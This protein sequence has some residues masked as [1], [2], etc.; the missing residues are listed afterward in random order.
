[1][2]HA[3]LLCFVANCLPRHPVNGEL[4]GRDDTALSYSVLESKPVGFL[5]FSSTA[6]LKSV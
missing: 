6:H 1:M 5:L 2:D 4:D 3:M